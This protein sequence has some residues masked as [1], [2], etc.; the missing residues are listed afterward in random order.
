MFFLMVCDHAKTADIATRRDAARADHRDW[1]TSGGGGLVKVL[2]GSAIWNADGEGIG[3]F[4]ILQAETEEKA[5]AFAEGDPF[6][7]SGIVTGYTMTRL[8]DGFR[9]ERIDPLTR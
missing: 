6:Y 7:I 3:N 5:R 8:A 4:G 2:T 9:A 1:V